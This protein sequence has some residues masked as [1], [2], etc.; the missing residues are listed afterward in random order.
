MPRSEATWA[1]SLSTSLKAVSLSNG[2]IATVRFAHLA[3]TEFRNS[4]KT[5]YD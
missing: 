1:S 5:S 4:P 2:W 3:M